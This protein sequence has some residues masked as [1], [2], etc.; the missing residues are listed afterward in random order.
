MIQRAAPR[1]RHRRRPTSFGEWVAATALLTGILVYNFAPGIEQALIGSTT[2]R[3]R[4]AAIERSAYYSN[5]N[6]ARAAG[7][8]PISRG[9]PGYRPEMDGDG[10]GVACE[11]VRF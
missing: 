10:D 4:E 11:P 5:C 3:D 9:S 1:R 8:A 6:A 2:M 7:V